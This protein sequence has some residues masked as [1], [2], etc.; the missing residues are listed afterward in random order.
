MQKLKAKELPDFS[1]FDAGDGQTQMF[2][3]IYVEIKN[4]YALDDEGA[5]EH[6]DQLRR[7]ARRVVFIPHVITISESH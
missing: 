2:Q 1:G 3:D 6:D 5:D 7:H 4:Q